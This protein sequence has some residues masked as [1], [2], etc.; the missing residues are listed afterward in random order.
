MPKTPATA[1]NPRKLAWQILLGVVTH[2][3]ST[4]QSL[5]P[6][7]QQ[8]APKDRALL[9]QLVFGTLRHWFEL[10]AEL[11]QRL[12]KPFK[13]KDRDLQLLLTLGL[14]QIRHTRIPAHAAL[15]ETVK[16]CPP[17]KRWAKGLINAVLR[18]ALDDNEPSNDQTKP[19][20][21]EWLVTRIQHDWPE[22][23]VSIAQ[24]SNQIAPLTLRAVISRDSFLQQL[25]DASIEA[26]AVT[27]TQA[28]IQL[29]QGHD[30]TQL[31]GYTAGAFVVQDSAAQLAAEILSPHSEQRL[32]DACAA[33]GG[34][35]THLLQLAPNATLTAI[36]SEPSRL[37]RVNENLARL[38]QTANVI[39]GDASKPEQWW[40]GAQ[41]DAIL[42]DAPCSA[43][44]VIRRH[45][46]IKL[47]RRDSDIETLVAL[48]GKILSAL[49]STLKPGG[50][51]LYC[52]CSILRCENDQQLAN[53]LA[54]QADAKE[55]L[56]DL[57]VGQA[58]QHGVQLLPG[59]SGGDGFYYCLLEKL[60]GGESGP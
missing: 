36:D 25:A 41:F 44:G 21:P 42:L 39:C 58:A 28:G 8:C 35:T 22:Q 20:L 9:Q 49:W 59:D 11:S 13:N 33:P 10:Q 56:L 32:L 50:R 15:N 45:P 6:A 18:R 53:F 60:G 54:S 12:S 26:Q 47:L 57:P 27:H 46:D 14:Y 16:L 24:Q 40:D 34:K 5:A 23:F 52:T 38:K 48:Q 3:Q 1:A 7:Q 19:D 51:L 30:I 4:A 2:G 37:E 55:L 29:Q 17:N 43:T 31:P